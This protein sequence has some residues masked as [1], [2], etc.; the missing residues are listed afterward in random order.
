MKFHI[1]IPLGVPDGHRLG[2]QEVQVLPGQGL[3]IAVHHRSQTL[4]RMGAQRHLLLEPL[5]NQL[6][7][8]VAALLWRVGLHQRAVHHQVLD[9]LFTLRSAGQM[10]TAQPGRDDPG[11]PGTT[12][13]NVILLKQH[14]ALRLRSLGVSQ[15]VQV[16]A[17]L[18]E[19]GVLASKPDLD[20]ALDNLW[21]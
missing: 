21:Q 5:Q 11:E 15:D 2:V 8:I 17:D 14:D 19:E 12:L 10:Q 6:G 13:P 16:N 18:L 20:I 3:C 9:V 7:V 1:G 4:W